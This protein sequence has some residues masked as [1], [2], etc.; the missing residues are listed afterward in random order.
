[1]GQKKVN[2]E[3]IKSI[4]AKYND[5]SANISKDS[6]IVN[7]NSKEPLEKSGEAIKSVSKNISETVEA[8]NKYLNGV[9][10]EF[11]KSDLAMAN[12]IEEGNLAIF[13]NQY[14]RGS[15]RVSKVD[16]KAYKK[17]PN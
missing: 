17:L 6:D 11:E 5:M 10:E 13:Q 9:A 7:D 12:G 3:K 2:T 4:D 15:H 8:L 1:M 16:N 14:V